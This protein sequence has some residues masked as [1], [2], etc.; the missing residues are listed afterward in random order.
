MTRGGL[1]A[2]EKLKGWPYRYDGAVLQGIGYDASQCHGVG[3]NNPV[4][5][6]DDSGNVK[7]Y[8]ED[9]I[10]AKDI[11]PLED[12][13]ANAK[14]VV[15][16]T[17]EQTRGALDNY[18]NFI[19]KT[20]SSFPLGG[21]EFGEKLK[22]YAEQNISATNEYVLKLSEAKDLQEVIRIQTEFVQTQFNAF[23]EQTKSLAETFTKAATE[24]VKMRF[25]KS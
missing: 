8:S 11:K 17:M 16:Q 2:I 24:T 25:Q 20:M 9:T 3:V 13:N 23:G 14:Q 5:I 4:S 15:E 1:R 6:D 18:F 7:S 21:T 19:Q 22:G 10:M 12:L